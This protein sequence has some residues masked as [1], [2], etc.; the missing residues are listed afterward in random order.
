MKKWTFACDSRDCIRLPSDR[1]RRRQTLGTVS[2]LVAGAR[3]CVCERRA[4][5]LRMESGIAME[6]RS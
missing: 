5:S 3:E 2:V 1:S 4:A 6:I